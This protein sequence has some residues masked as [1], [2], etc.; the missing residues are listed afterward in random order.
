M[1]SSCEL[2]MK[3]CMDVYILQISF[4]LYKILASLQQ[5]KVRAL[6]THYLIAALYGRH[7][8]C[9]YIENST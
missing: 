5:I 4:L 8:N 7:N 9:G 2:S 1:P 6:V 3:V